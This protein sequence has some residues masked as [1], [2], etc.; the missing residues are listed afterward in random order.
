[1]AP[2]RGR[3]SARSRIAR[4]NHGLMALSRIIN[5]VL[6]TVEGPYDHDPALQVPMLPG[7]QGVLRLA[8]LP[9]DSDDYGFLRAQLVRERNRVAD[10]LD[11]AAEHIE[12]LS[13]QV[14]GR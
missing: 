6:Y 14:G 1:S 10:A 7:L 12:F 8:T 11:G 13:A 2:R 5:P 4:F 3:G 9:I